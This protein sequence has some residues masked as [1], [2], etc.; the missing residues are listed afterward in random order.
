M[1][2]HLTERKSKKIAN[3]YLRTIRNIEKEQNEELN[4]N[5][6]NEKEISRLSLLL[7]TRSSNRT[8]LKPDIDSRRILHDYDTQT[9]LNAFQSM[10]KT[11]SRLIYKFG[12]TP[13]RCPSPNRHGLIELNSS[14]E[15]YQFPFKKVLPA[16]KSYEKGVRAKSTYPYSRLEKADSKEQKQLKYN[17]PF[18][19]FYAY[20]GLCNDK[21]ERHI[22]EM[23]GI[24]MEDQRRLRE[25]W[26]KNFIE[27]F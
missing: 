1:I 6:R 2:T 3:S 25:E 20:C 26:N 15:E 16:V 4:A 27:D 10:L 11:R 19:L 5:N 17:M 12:P 22:K 7:K 9:K 18:K 8:M 21:N 14:T 23:N 13:E 24:T